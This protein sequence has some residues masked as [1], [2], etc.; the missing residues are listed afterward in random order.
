MYS[1]V[2]VLCWYEHAPQKVPSRVG[3][4]AREQREHLLFVR[5]A[6][7]GWYF[8]YSTSN[9]PERRWLVP[10]D[11]N[12]NRDRYI[13][14]WAYGEQLHFLATSFVPQPVAEQVVADF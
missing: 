10:L 11:P 7:R 6:K 12:A 1:P 9:L 8:E 2:G 4:G 5:H 14:Q 3:I 13:R